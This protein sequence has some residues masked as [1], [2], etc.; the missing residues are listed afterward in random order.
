MRN[1]IYHLLINKSNNSNFKMNF[2]TNKIFNNNCNFKMIKI[3]LVINHLHLLFL[4]QSF[5]RIINN[6]ILSII[7]K[8][9]NSHNKYST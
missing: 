9:N 7:I 6:Q 8:Y 3:I 1:Q 2:Y 5:L 4:L